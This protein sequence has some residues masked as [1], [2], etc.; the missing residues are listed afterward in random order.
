MPWPGKP[1]PANPKLTDM[2][3]GQNE[4][5]KAF[6]DKWIPDVIDECTAIQE[7]FIEGLLTL[8][9]DARAGT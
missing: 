4:R 6:L 7:A 9:D 5:N 8:M 3:A 1:Q 2:L